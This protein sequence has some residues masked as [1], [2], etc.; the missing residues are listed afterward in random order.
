MPAAEDVQRQIAIAVVIAV[1]VPAFLFAVEA[2]IGGVEIEHDT[3]R[4]LGVGI[5][6]KIDEEPLDRA[7]VVVELVVTILA[8]LAGV[9]HATERRLAGKRAAR[10]VEHG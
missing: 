2:I 3:D 10:L 4:R 6:K 5:E 9:L 8:D 7:A 1:E